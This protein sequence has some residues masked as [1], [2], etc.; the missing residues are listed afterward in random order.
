MARKIDQA[1]L[2]ENGE[3]TP[4]IGD[5]YVLADGVEVSLG[6]ITVA[7]SEEASEIVKDGDYACMKFLVREK[8]EVDEKECYFGMASRVVLDFFTLLNR[9]MSPL[10]QTLE[11]FQPE[12]ET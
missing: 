6:A 5:T 12:Q 11:G 8:V 9:I 4:M 10:Y 2:L 3:Y 7:R 1:F